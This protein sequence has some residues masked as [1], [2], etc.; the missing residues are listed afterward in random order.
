MGKE[1]IV[2]YLFHMNHYISKKLYVKIAEAEIKTI[3]II[4]AL[5]K[6]TTPLFFNYVLDKIS[7]EFS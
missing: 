6:K 4:I 3:F 2:N 1:T 5:E 7:K